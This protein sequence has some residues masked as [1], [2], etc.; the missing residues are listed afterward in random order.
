MK[1]T[2]VFF[3]VRRF[4]QDHQYC[5]FNM[6]GNE[7]W[8]QVQSR[9]ISRCFSKC[10]FL[11]NDGPVANIGMPEVTSE[12]LEL[13]A[14]ETVDAGEGGYGGGWQS[15][16]KGKIPSCLYQRVYTVH[17]ITMSFIQIQLN[18]YASFPSS[19]CREIHRCILVVFEI[20]SL[21]FFYNFFVQFMGSVK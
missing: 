13:Q 9:T 19:F 7:G 20:S 11:R 2:K 21:C 14:M 8:S 12:E 15:Q 18:Q 16:G 4:L 10:G 17:N 1:H 5:S 3:L 6:L